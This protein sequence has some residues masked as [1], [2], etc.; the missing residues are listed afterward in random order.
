MYDSVV[1]LEPGP[2]TTP[3]STYTAVSGP[4]GNFPGFSQMGAMA[5]GPQAG[6]GPAPGAATEVAAIFF[7]LNCTFLRSASQG[8]FFA[9]LDIVLG[10]QWGSKAILDTDSSKQLFLDFV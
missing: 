1:V 7:L 10:T 2:R 5:S 4:C 8:I 3:P 9:F 6:A